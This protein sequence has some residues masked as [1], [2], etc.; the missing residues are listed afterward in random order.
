MF[1]SCGAQ[2]V[3]A[4]TSLPLKKHGNT[5]DCLRCEG[6]WISWKSAGFTSCHTPEPTFCADRSIYYQYLHALQLNQL[7]LMLYEWVHWKCPENDA[8]ITGLILALGRKTLRGSNDD[9]MISS[10]GRHDTMKRKWVYW[11][12]YM[13]YA[14]RS[15]IEETIIA[16]ISTI[17]RY[18]CTI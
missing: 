15:K 9:R 13:H 10:I 3:R 11:F 14:G 8:K 6:C 2:S 7:H 4:F 1:Y 5:Q 16:V 18:V 12:K 17:C